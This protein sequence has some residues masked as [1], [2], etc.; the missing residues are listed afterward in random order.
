MIRV[1]FVIGVL[2]GVVRFSAEASPEGGR[3]V[4]GIE[5]PA[6]P[7]RRSRRSDERKLSRDQSNQAMSVSEPDRRLSATKPL[8][9]S[10]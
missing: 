6:P 3:S 8:S 7:T 10:T 4:N 9:L 5:P 2:S 1:G